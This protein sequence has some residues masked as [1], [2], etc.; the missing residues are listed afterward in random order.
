M[1]YIKKAAAQYELMK[2]AD[3]FQSLV[4]KYAEG[5]R[6]V[7]LKI[8]VT[9]AMGDFLRD[10][11][12]RTNAR[13]ESRYAKTY[14]EEKGD[15]VYTLK[16]EF[17]KSYQASG[18]EIPAGPTADPRYVFGC[19]IAQGGNIWTHVTKPGGDPEIMVERSE[20][21]VDVKPRTKNAQLFSQTADF[22]ALRKIVSF[23]AKA[24]GNVVLPENLIEI[25]LNGK[26]IIPK[27]R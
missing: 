13:V 9:E 12:T 20:Y 15:A 11:I 16:P 14:T 21:I 3:S 24:K 23:E 25:R 27:G 4:R 2:L 6:Q 18:E 7:E 8:G 22:R 17:A 1:S 10:A 19:G 5:E 26:T